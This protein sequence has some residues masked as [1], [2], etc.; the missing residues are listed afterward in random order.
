VVVSRRRHLR[1][2]APGTKLSRAGQAAVD[3]AAA[4]LW[5]TAQVAPERPPLSRYQRRKEARLAAIAAERARLEEVAHQRR[6]IRADKR[7]ARFEQS[8]QRWLFENPIQ[9]QC[10][11]CHHYGL[12]G[13]L[14][15]HRWFGIPDNFWS[16][17]PLCDTCWIECT[18]FFSR[19]RIVRDLDHRIDGDD[20]VLFL[21]HMLKKPPIWLKKLWD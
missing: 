6:Q 12:C 2:V 14:W 5:P 4:G 19:R 13:G 11:L 8:R 21:A 10:A 1:G 15:R 17:A 18:R 3:A 7:L 20:V 16:V 9:G